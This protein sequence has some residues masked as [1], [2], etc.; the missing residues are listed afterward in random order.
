MSDLANPTETAVAR[1]LKVLTELIKVDIDEGDKAGVEYFRKAGEKL[2]EAREAY[3]EGKRP[4]DFYDWATSK[5]DKSTTQIRTYISLAGHATGKSFESLRDFERKAQKQPS[6][7]NRP[8]GM[9]RGWTAP[10]DAEAQKARDDA[11]RLAAQEELTRRQE[12]EAEAKLGLR[13]IAIG[14]KVLAAELHPDKV[15]GSKEAM[16]RLNRVRDRLKVN[17]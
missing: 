11:R 15:G 6:R 9:V 16:S 14:Y 13:L 17:V 5:F 8:R 1:P 2:I 3:F 7:V 4:S 12:R 10:V